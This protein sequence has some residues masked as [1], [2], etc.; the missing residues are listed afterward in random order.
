MTESET[1]AIPYPAVDNPSELPQ[2]APDG[3]IAPIEGTG[4]TWMKVGGRWRPMN[5]Y[6]V[7]DF[8]ELPENVPDGTR[9]V[10]N[11]ERGVR[12]FYI[13]VQGGWAVDGDAEMKYNWSRERRIEWKLD[14]ILTMLERIQSSQT[15]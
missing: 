7:D 11:L 5:P 12:N 8:D 2:D 13:K 3:A 4:V 6:V 1:P 10:L 9:G 14:R 15:S